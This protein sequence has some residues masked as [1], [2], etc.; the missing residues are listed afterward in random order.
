[1]EGDVSFTFGHYRVVRK[2]RRIERDGTLLPVGNRAFDLLLVLLLSAGEVVDKRELLAK[3]WPDVTVD[4]GSLRFCI[5]RLRKA[6]GDGERNARFIINVAGRGYSFVAPVEATELQTSGHPASEL[7]S[8]AR[9]T[10]AATESHPAFYQKPASPG[11]FAL[12]H[13][14]MRRTRVVGRAYD[15]SAVA[16]ALQAER[17]VTVVGPGGIGKTTLALLVAHD[18][19]EAFGGEVCFVDFSAAQDPGV[20]AIVVAASIGLTVRSGDVQESLI[21]HLRERKILMIW[22]NCE[23]LIEVLAELSERIYSECAGTWILATSREALQV[24]GENIYRLPPLS[25][26]SDPIPISADALLSYPAAQLFVDRASTAGHPLELVEEEVDLVASICRKLDGMA[27]AIE[28]AASRV[29]VFGLRET[30]ALLDSRMRLLWRGRRTAPARQR[31]LDATV[32]WSYSLLSEIERVVLRRLSVFVGMF[33]LEAAQAVAVCPE[34]SSSSIMEALEGLFNKSLLTTELEKERVKY[35]I[36]EITRN[37][38]AEKLAQAGYKHDVSLRHARHYQSR[39][40]RREIAGDSPSYH[41]RGEILGNVRAALNW[42]FSEE[43]DKSVAVALASVALPMFFEL[44]LFAECQSWATYALTL[45]RAGDSA[46]DIEM[47]LHAFLAMS[48]MFTQGN[49]SGVRHSLDRALQIAKSAGGLW[50]QLKLLGGLSIYCTRIGHFQAAV[51]YA[52]EGATISE[53]AGDHAATTISQWMLGVS[54]HLMGDQGRALGSCQT[55]LDAPPPTDQL[56]ASELAYYHRIRTMLALGRALWLRGLPDQAFN[57]AERTLQEASDAGPA[58]RGISLM[59]T[60]AVFGWCGRLDRAREI[61]EEVIAHATANRLVPNQAIGQGLKGELL[62]RRG[63]AGE[64]LQIVRG[65]LRMLE[66]EQYDIMTTVFISAAA[67][68]LA[69]LGA[70]DEALKEIDKAIDL[71]AI[72]GDTF[73]APELLRIK[74]CLLAL[75]GDE[76]CQEAE[77]LLS[78]S[79]LIAQRQCALSWELRTARSLAVILARAGRVADAKSALA[80]VFERFTEGSETWDLRSAGA[81]LQTLGGPRPVAWNEL[82]REEVVSA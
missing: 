46:A 59:W 30:A 47:N 21:D 13:L 39:L 57:V 81:V 49:G 64:G 36:L 15:A 70:L 1:V 68:G 63:R 24:L 79:L 34:V 80:N 69:A 37:F 51:E 18:L 28:L 74:G 54:L 52:A 33:S 20:A 2:E 14:P 67:K 66:A 72:A 10:F 5:A 55:A 7:T 35:R 31:T 50:D 6:L 40:A 76:R 56:R 16:T 53:L 73:D 77:A 65:A 12:P 25:F 9:R 17:F 71:V 38:A 42:A 61:T 8:I 60:V 27:L 41:L 75:S 23:H 62:I 22:D 82:L 43:G 26:P 58:T 78:N 11:A 32:D 29:G 44:S 3:V 19:L 48:L 45:V 4:E